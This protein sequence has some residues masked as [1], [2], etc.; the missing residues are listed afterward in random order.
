MNQKSFNRR[1]YWFPFTAAIVIILSICSVTTSAQ[2]QQ[3]IKDTTAPGINQNRIK[4]IDDAMAE[5]NK[6]MAKL[7]EEIKKI[8]WD[9]MQLDINQSLKEL[10][11]AKMRM[12]IDKALKD[13]DVEKVKASAEEAVAK[14][15]WEGIKK[16]IDNLKDIEIPKL[17]ATVKNM[18][19][20]LEKSMQEAKKGIEK[21]KVEMKSYKDFIDDLASDGLINKKGEYTIEIKDD[22]LIINGNTQPAE[23]NNKYRQFLESHK[24][25]TIKKSKDNFN[26]SDNK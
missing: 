6:G 10:D 15:N 8:D 13:I 5:L 9:K 23:V 14:I 11:T 1:Y 22:H 17:E 26:I 25:V 16:N 12:D 4:D 21:A 24:N 2:H 3:I 7:N 20:Q 18:K 19:P